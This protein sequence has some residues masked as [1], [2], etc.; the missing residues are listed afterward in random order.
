MKEK[1]TNHIILKIL[2]PEESNSIIF[3]AMQALY[4]KI[5][6]TILQDFFF[7]F[8]AVMHSYNA[9]NNCNNVIFIGQWALEYELHAPGT[10]VCV[11]IVL[12]LLCSLD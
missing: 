8:L 11:I 12:L 2:W 9:S 5:T 1:Y 4:K 6:A 3:N 10:N 7:I